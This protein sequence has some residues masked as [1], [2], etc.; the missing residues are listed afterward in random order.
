M[1]SSKK[2]TPSVVRA[3]T[4]QRRPRLLTYSCFTRRYRFG[5]L[6]GQGFRHTQISCSTLDPA[7]EEACRPST[8]GIERTWSGM[9]ESRGCPC[10]IVVLNFYY[11]SRSLSR[12]IKYGSFTLIHQFT[13]VCT[14]PDMPSS[15]PLRHFPGGNSAGE[16][17]AL[18]AQTPQRSEGFSGAG[19]G[20]GTSTNQMF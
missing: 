10:S 15:C 8:H 4:S 12:R 17:A 11:H 5:R 2:W 6:Q 7:V 16:R 13:A 18:R 9:L 14:H 3:P 19:Y 1:R 20:L